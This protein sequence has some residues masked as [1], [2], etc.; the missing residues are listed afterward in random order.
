MKTILIPTD[1][2]A[3]ATHAAEYGYQ[4]AKQIKG[5]IILCNAFIIPAELPEAG[6]VVWPMYEYDEIEESCANDLKA[7]KAKLETD[8]GGFRP[9]IKCINETGR[10]QDVVGEILERYDIELVVMAT[11]RA[12]GMGDFMLTNHSRKMIECTTKPLLL[13]PQEA[14]YVPVRKIAFATDL[15]DIDQDLDAIFQLVDYARLFNAEILL[16]YVNHKKYDTVE[17]KKNMEEILTNLSNKADY[18]FIYY[19]EIKSHNAE[20]G[21]DWLCHHGQIDMLAMVHRQNSILKQLLNGSHT[22]RMAGHITKPLL[23]FPAKG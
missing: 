5:K 13:I 16:A 4:F 20:S 6:N 18:P 22:Q 23:V 19:R 7:L 21:L 9:A 15:E 11:H 8:E 14:K 12:A 10:L 3:N 17:F 2:S 1:F